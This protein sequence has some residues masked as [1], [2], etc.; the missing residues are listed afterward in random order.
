M[1]AVNV[2]EP[3]ARGQTLKNIRKRIPKR[4]STNVM[5]V[6]NPSARACISQNTRKFIVERKQIYIL[7]VGKPLDKTPLFNMKNLASFTL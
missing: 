2:G 4:N 6:E 5:S 7:S 1:S 3:S